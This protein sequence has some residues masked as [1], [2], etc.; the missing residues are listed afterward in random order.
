[1]DTEEPAVETHESQQATDDD[2]SVLVLEE[3]NF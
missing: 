3:K 1:M 2:D